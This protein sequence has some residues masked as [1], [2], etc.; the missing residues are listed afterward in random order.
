[1]DEPS[2]PRP[3]F[4]GRA[5]A[6]LLTA[7]SFTIVAVSG[8]VV[9]LAPPADAA[10]RVRWS[11]LGLARADWVAMLAIAGWVLAIGC[12]LHLIYNFKQL[13]GHIKRTSGGFPLRPEFLLATALALL[14]VASAIWRLPP[15][16][17]LADLGDR[18]WGS[19]AE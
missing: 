13:V 8:A 4:Q 7:W 15:L 1:M 19:L 11:M 3:S 17:Y 16:G 6:S 5:F 12:G 9:Y 10:A 14:V 18:L 2:K